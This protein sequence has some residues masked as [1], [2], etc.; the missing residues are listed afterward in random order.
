MIS[1]SAMT[2]DLWALAILTAVCCLFVGAFGIAE[3]QRFTD[4]R[5]APRHRRRP[6]TSDWSWQVRKLAS[7]L[8]WK[9]LGLL[10]LAITLIAAAAA[11]SFPILR[12]DRSATR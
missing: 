11:A 5:P 9:A 4:P 2:P 6:S 3:R 10:T 1:V 8:R 7:D 12:P